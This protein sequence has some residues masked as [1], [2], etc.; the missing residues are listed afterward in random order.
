MKITEAKKKKELLERK[1]LKLCQEF[2]NQTGLQIQGVGVDR[3]PNATRPSG[4][5]LVW[6]ATTIHL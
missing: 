1:I 4:D 2:E 3:V 6:I 5:E